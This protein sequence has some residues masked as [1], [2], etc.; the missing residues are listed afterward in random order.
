MSVETV[1]SNGIKIGFVFFGLVMVIVG[2]SFAQD[3]P[4]QDAQAVQGYITGGDIYKNHALGMTI[5]LPGVWELMPGTA[6]K[7]PAD[8]S[9]R[10]PLCGAP[11]IDVTLQQKA[12]TSTHYKIFIAGYKLPRLYQDRQRYP[13]QRLAGVMLQGSMNGSGLT[14]MGP[15]ESI[16][17]DGK[18]AY[19]LL[20]GH[21]GDQIAKAVGY[22]AET[23]G[24]IFLI[25][26]AAPS[27]PDQ[28]TAAIEKMS[29]HSVP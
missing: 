17:L 18:T 20:A 25:V 6:K 5:M 12:P 14:P 16:R 23:N 11:E 10:G 7:A 27:S 15:Q 28:L 29:L 9:C 3:S 24:Y 19:R 1:M 21:P 2:C 26:L 4:R 8:T 13:L 22:V